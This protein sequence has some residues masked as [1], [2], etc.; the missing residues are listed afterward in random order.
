[1]THSSL[2]A[3]DASDDMAASCT[4]CCVS[5]ISARRYGFTLARSFSGRP[6]ISASFAVH[7]PGVAALQEVEILT[8]FD[9]AHL[10]VHEARD[11]GEEGIGESCA[12]A[13]AAALATSSST[14]FNRL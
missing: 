14:A 3:L 5:P 8:A 9:A 10:A 7:A 4:S 6:A 13:L 11:V 12:T 2:A 1:M